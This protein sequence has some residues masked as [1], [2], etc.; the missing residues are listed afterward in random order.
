MGTWCSH[1][2]TEYN[3]AKYC[4]QC[5][6]MLLEKKS[7]RPTFSRMQI[8]SIAIIVPNACVVSLMTIILFFRLAFALDG[9]AWGDKADAP[10]AVGLSLLVV[11]VGVLSFLCIRKPRPLLLVAVVLLSLPLNIPIFWIFAEPYYEQWNAKVYLSAKD[12]QKAAQAR[13]YLSKVGIR[14]VFDPVIKE[15]VTDLRES[16]DTAKQIN[17]ADMIGRLSN[18]PRVADQLIET[19]KQIKDNPQK[20]ELTEKISQALESISPF[21]HDC[22]LIV[23]ERWPAATDQTSGHQPRMTK[24]EVIASANAKAAEQGY[25]L[26]QYEAPR[27]KFEYGKITRTWS[28]FYHTTEKNHD[29]DVLAWVN[30]QSGICSFPFSRMKQ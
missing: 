2:K 11:L 29:K 25:N 20:A 26:Y 12:P 1:C 18:D 4:R 21:H 19:Y 7:S 13:E 5:G 24:E 22:L 28:V 10:A 9:G 17:A 15:L 27:I 14:G 6:R 23:S 3:S 8:I 30:D 16:R